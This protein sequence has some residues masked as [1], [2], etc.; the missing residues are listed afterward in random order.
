MLGYVKAFKPELTFREYETYKAVYCSLCRDIGRRYG[1]VRRMFLSYDFTFLALMLMAANGETPKYEKK[2]CVCNPL[3][4][5]HYCSER[6]SE[7]AFAAAVTMAL[8][9]YKVCDDIAD[10]GFFKSL[11]RR[12]I[13]PLLKRSARRAYKDFPQLEEIILKYKNGQAEV[14]SEQ[15]GSIDRA[16]EPSAVSLGEIFSLTAKEESKKRILYRLGYCLGKW[17]Y[18]LDAGEDIEE[19]IKKGS[20]NP[21]KERLSQLG[22][23]PNKSKACEFLTPNLRVCEVECQKAFEL[24]GVKSY[25]TLLENILYLGL[26]N[27]RNTAFSEKPRRNKKQGVIEI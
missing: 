13:H 15:C 9:E 7:I 5:C 23:T 1:A 6:H 21:L 24:L 3:K 22:E 27:S 17:I 8:C 18:L 12:L 14:Q 16:A 25:K 2:R 26:H 10:E 4:S 11:A 20:F 19:D